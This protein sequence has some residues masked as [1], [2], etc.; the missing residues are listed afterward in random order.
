MTHETARG[1]VEVISCREGKARDG[2]SLSQAHPVPMERP[3]KINLLIGKDTNRKRSE[4][5]R[6]PFKKRGDK[7]FSTMEQSSSRENERPKEV[8]A[9]GGNR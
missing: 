7:H 3:I 8:H 4:I 5:H 1:E 2:N 6:D 9:G